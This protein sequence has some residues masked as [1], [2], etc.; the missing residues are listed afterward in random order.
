MTAYMRWLAA[1][2]GSTGDDYDG[3]VALVGGRA[4]GLLGVDLG[5]LRGARRRRPYARCSPS[6]RCPGRSG[7]PAPSSTTP[8][9]SSAASADERRRGA[10]RLRAARPRRADLGRAARPVAA[11]PAGLRALGVERGDRVV[12]YLP[13]IPEALIAF[14]ATASIGAIWSSCSPDFGAERRRP[15]R[16]DRAQ[17][18][19]LRRRL[20][21]QRPRLRPPRRRRRAG[22]RDADPRAHVVVPYLDPEP[23][24]GAARARRSPGTSCW[25]PARAPSSSSSGCPST[26]RSGSSTPRARPACRRRSSRATAGS[27]SSSSR[28][29]TSTSTPRRAT[30]S[31]GSPPPAG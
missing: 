20:P 15:L 3:A 6:G 26:I 21:L 30:A 25:R 28:S 9:T 27:C 13:N 16:P 18:A 19:V 24:L 23:D 5:L 2:R 29:S 31:S 8:S 22:G 7:S 14:L 1:E 10:A 4:R 12:A 11:S 17:G